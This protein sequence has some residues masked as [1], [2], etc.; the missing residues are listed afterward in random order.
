MTKRDEIEFKAKEYPHHEKN[1]LWYIGIGLLVVVAVILTIKYHNYLLSGVAIA[2]GLAVFSMARQK[3]GTHD[4]RLTPKGIYWGKDFFAYH[5]LKAFW[6]ADAGGHT[7]V[8]LE[9]LNLNPVL[10]FVVA[11]SEIEK[12]ADYLFCHLPWH[13]HKNEPI[14]DRLNRFFKI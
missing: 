14:P 10:S 5:H 1:A 9:R 7:T 13:D 3:P 4:V 2:A 8:Y 12:I 6:I 11:D